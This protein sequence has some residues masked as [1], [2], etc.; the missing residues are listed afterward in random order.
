MQGTYIGWNE[1]EGRGMTNFMNH[2]GTGGGGFNFSV[3]D[4]NGGILSIP[5]TIYGN[6]I[7]GIGTTSPVTKLSVTSDTTT[8]T[9]Y[10]VNELFQFHG[11]TATYGTVSNDTTTLGIGTYDSGNDGMFTSSAEGGF[12]GTLNSAPLNFRVTNAERMRIDTNGNIGIGT[13][14]PQSRLSV[15]GPF[16]G[17]TSGNTQEFMR[18]GDS[19]GG[20]AGDS[21]RIVG[22]RDT[23]AANVGE[24]TTQRY[25]LGRNVDSVYDSAA[26]DFIGDGSMGLL[27]NSAERVRISSSGNVGIGTT[28]PA[29]KLSVAGTIESTSGGYKFPDGTVQT[30]A[31]SGGGL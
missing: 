8:K 29:Q 11:G 20:V 14:S 19:R 4:N 5:M 28:T 21:I 15:Q 30:S 6:G 10:D 18:V 16:T 27:A 17:L 23:T 12:V 26:I 1:D 9:P 13:I 31:A 22:I 3:F 2:R 7:V 24:W 25:R